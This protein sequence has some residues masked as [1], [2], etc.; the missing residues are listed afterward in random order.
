VKGREGEVAVAVAKGIGS[1]G[2][3]MKEEGGGCRW[4]E[5]GGVR[6]GGGGYT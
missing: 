6:K 2:G 3:A 5:A 1:S 4:M